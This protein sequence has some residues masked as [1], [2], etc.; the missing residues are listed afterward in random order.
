MSKG[1]KEQKGAFSNVT[2]TELA[3]LC[4]VTKQAVA[5]WQCPR[6]DDG[7]YD[8]EVVF[9]WIIS[10]VKER[11]GGSD[12]QAD[13][14]LTRWRE[15]RAEKAELELEELRDSLVRP[16]VIKDML[17]SFSGI[18]KS[19]HSKMLSEHPIAAQIFSDALREFEERLEE[20]R[21]GK[22]EESVNTRQNKES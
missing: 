16:E 6:N 3:R 15:A 2:Q 17:R 14:A 5:Q 1:R 19:A 10:R 4:G 20:W 21:V 22:E 13:I 18:L 11:Y 8:L 9:P 12:K 7:T